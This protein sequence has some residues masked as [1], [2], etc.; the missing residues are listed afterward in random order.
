MAML[1][2]MSAGVSAAGLQWSAE[3]Q[4]VFTELC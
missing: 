4:F 1:A 2:E 3:V